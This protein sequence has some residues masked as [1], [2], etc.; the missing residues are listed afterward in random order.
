MGKATIVLVTLAALG[1][2][3][4]I[5]S[6]LVDEVEPDSVAASP[7]QQC[8]NLWDRT[9]TPDISECRVLVSMACN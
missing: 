4:L 1:L 5:G 6:S 9:R 2:G 7:V 3:T 8:S